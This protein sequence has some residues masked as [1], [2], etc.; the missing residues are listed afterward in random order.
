MT[1][2]PVPEKNPDMKIPKRI[3]GTLLHSL[4]AGVVPRFGLEYIAIGRQAEI[5]ALVNDLALVEEGGASMRFIVGRYGSGKSFLL[6][7]MRGHCMERGFVC[8]D[9]DLTPERRFSGTKGQG[10]ATY[11]ELMTNLAT[12]ASP[13]GG[14][15]PLV[16]SRWFERL[17]TEIVTNEGLKPND[18]RFDTRMRD[19]IYELTRELEGLVCGFDFAVTLQAYYEAYRGGDDDKLS[20]AQKWL[21]GEF[22]NRVEARMALGV[23]TI[24]DDNN[25]YDALKLWARFVRHIGYGGLIVCIDECV[26]LYKIP[27]RI[28]RENNYEKI[29]SMFNDTMQGKASGLGLILCGTPQFLEDPRRGLYSY[30]ALKSRLA[31][32]RFGATGGFVNLMGPII[33]LNRLSNEE[34]FALCAR[35]SKLYAQYYPTAPDITDGQ[36]RD[37]LQACFSSIGADKLMTPR[38]IIRDYLA[39]S[40]IMMQN[41]GLPFEQIVKAAGGGKA[42]AVADPDEAPLPVAS[43]DDGNPIDIEI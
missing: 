4:A 5:G 21:R 43:E 40:A 13:E 28:S 3:L 24:I 38:E 25:W 37:F 27:N 14:A 15:L 22:T 16:L 36:R 35:L 11:R 9:A 6:Q 17:Q 19:R 23:T 31:D 39:V 32:S 18:V 12:K 7:L 1:N 42:S 41:P 34:V 20:A 33:R 30:E 10:V 29:L 2:P 8:A 26:N